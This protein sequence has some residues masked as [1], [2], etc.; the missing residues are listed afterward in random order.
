M[1][2]KTVTCK[3]V[4]DLVCPWCWVGKRSLENAAKRKPEVVVEMKWFPFF[5]NK[6]IPPEGVDKMAHYQKKFGPR[7]ERM[8]KDPNNQLCRTGAK[9]GIA[10]NYKDGC[11]VSNSMK[12]HRLMHHTLETH[13]WQKQNDLMEAIFYKYFTENEDLGRDEVLLAAARSVQL[14]ESECMKVLQSNIHEDEVNRLFAASSNNVIP[15]Y[16]FVLPDSSV[17]IVHRVLVHRV[18]VHRVLVR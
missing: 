6:N 7:A 4:S 5:L 12:G 18:L 10:F 13:G 17:R 1:A 11:R 8:L 16:T 3:I 14:D 2:K 9:L 15:H